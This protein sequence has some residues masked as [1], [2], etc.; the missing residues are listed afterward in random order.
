MPYEKPRQG[1]YWG[2]FLGAAPAQSEKAGKWYYGLTFRI[3]HISTGQEKPD[4]LA[5]PMQQTVRFYFDE[6][7]DKQISMSERN[8]RTLL[9]LGFNGDFVAGTFRPEIEQGIWLTCRW[10]KDG[11]YANWYIYES[12]QNMK[13]KPAAVMPQ[14]MAD[15]LNAKLKQFKD[16]EPAPF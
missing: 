2:L 14:D 1:T 16:S 15:M 13:Q 12:E 7:A 6:D 8:S 10:S 9:G 5:Q 3:T 4:A 11:Q